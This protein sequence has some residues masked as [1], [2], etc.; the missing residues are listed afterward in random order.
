[1]ATRMAISTA[2]KS[3]PPVRRRS[4]K[5]RCRRESTSRAISRW[6]SVAVFFL[7]RPGALLWLGRT[8]TADLPVDGN[9][10]RTNSLEP[11][12][13][14]DFS[15]GFAEGG[16]SREALGDCLAVNFASE[17]ELRVMAGIVGLSAMKGWACRSVGPLR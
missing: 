5:I 14:L 2:S 4:A 6:I 13:L 11:M 16:G 8:E 7:W 17:T 10:V 15:L 9:Q 3:R 1:M 12:E